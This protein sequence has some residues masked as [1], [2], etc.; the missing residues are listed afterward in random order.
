MYKT[1]FKWF[2]EGVNWAATYVSSFME[3][4][5][6]I[7]SLFLDVRTQAQNILLTGHLE[8]IGEPK[9]LHLKLNMMIIWRDLLISVEI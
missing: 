1:L 8:F 6:E 9:I 4:Y 7:D 3:A 2:R 5:M